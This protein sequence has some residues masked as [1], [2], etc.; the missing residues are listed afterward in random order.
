MH[1]ADGHPS[2][3]ER[4]SLESELEPTGY[5]LVRQIAEG[6]MGQ[7]CEVEHVALGKRQAMKLL[8]PCYADDPGL[9]DRLR[10]EAQV[11]AQLES[12]NI[13]QVLDLGRTRSG[14]PFLVTE[15]L[16]GQSLRDLLEREG[17][18]AAE[19]AVDY[20]VQA[21]DGL[22]EAHQAGL[23]HRDIKPSNI[24]VCEPDRRGKRVAKVIDF[25]VVKV[26][27]DRDGRAPLYPTA[28]G[29]L[30]GTPTFASPE[31]LACEPV[32]VRSDIYCV[33]L[34]LYTL[35]AG[36]GP[37][38]QADLMDRVRAQRTEVA[39]PPSRFAS[40][41]IPSSLDAA[42]VKALAREPAERFQSAAEMAQALREIDLGPSAGKIDEQ[43]PAQPDSPPAPQAPPGPTAM[44][45]PWFA[46]EP[47]GAGPSSPPAAE[48]QGVNPSAPP[49]APQGASPPAP[50]PVP[51]GATPSAAPPPAPQ[52]FDP[53][54]AAPLAPQGADPTASAALAPD[55]HVRRSAAIDA[56]LY[57]LLVAAS[58][59]F[60][61]ALLRTAGLF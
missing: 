29:A 52:G 3:S 14:R 10:V 16:R 38:E 46:A 6:G 17:T 11:T 61:L 36:R 19:Q 45:N 8:L 51:Q 43:A 35:L 28:Q 32:D 23:V 40:Q 47:Q 25:G 58:A 13:L 20:I 15:L 27:H 55:G 42:I 22:E 56:A 60:V 49:P 21:L 53:S 59:A 26:P 44:I 7:I 24:F 5:R 41:P 48:P 18:L 33:G 1:D 30:V 54:V 9:G 4:L 37:F 12:A 39:P 2:R 50:P 31:Q 34:V 57:F